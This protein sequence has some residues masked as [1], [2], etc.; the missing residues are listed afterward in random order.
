M[1]IRGINLLAEMNE[2]L[3]GLM[4]FNFYTKSFAPFNK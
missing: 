3:A 1:E 2:T 4:P